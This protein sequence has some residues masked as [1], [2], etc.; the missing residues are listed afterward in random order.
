MQQP[1]SLLPGSPEAQQQQQQTRQLHKKRCSSSPD[2]T[3][4]PVQ[5][6]AAKRHA[7]K[8]GSA[9]GVAETGAGRAVG[10]L[11]ASTAQ[12]QEEQQGKAPAMWEQQQ[13]QQLCN[14]LKAPPAG[15]D[16]IDLSQDD[17][18]MEDAAALAAAAAAAV[19]SR[20]TAAFPNGRLKEQQQASK[21]QTKGSSRHA[22]PPVPAAA[23]AAVGTRLPITPGIHEVTKPRDM[24]QLQALLA[25]SPAWGFSV[26]FDSDSA[27]LP[28]PTG[29]TGAAAA[30]VAA[31]AAADDDWL[32][33]GVPVHQQQQQQQ[34]RSKQWS[35]SVLGVAFSVADGCAYYVPLTRKI[36]GV[37][38]AAGD[39]LRVGS[40]E[41]LKQLWQGL[42]DVFCSSSRGDSRGGSRGPADTS[43]SSSRD[44]SI[45]AVAAA[46]CACTA[47]VDS[48]VD[49]ALAAAA[50]TAQFS[51]VN[52]TNICP[53]AAAADAWGFCTTSLPNSSSS[54]SCVSLGATYGLKSQLAALASPPAASGFGGFVVDAAV[55]DVRIAAWLLQPDDKSS[56]EDT[57]GAAGRR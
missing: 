51:D 3:L 54:S 44:A 16:V 28:R 50:T 55:V 24:Q 37:V 19:A 5:Q 27:A 43:N 22:T 10:P 29:R 2:S 6:P 48:L 49:P 38:E 23:A 53:P 1:A 4:Q 36:P 9:A 34:R 15:V 56:E 32:T 31:A 40:S 47:A 46:A 12:Q 41:R 21:L 33:D 7:H 26:A 18:G 35:W 17:E 52:L 11:A 8:A 20:E 25:A 14:G 57:R 30:A 13:Q 42:A 45:A 39:P